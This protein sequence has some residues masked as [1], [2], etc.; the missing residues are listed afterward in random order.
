VAAGQ[1]KRLKSRVPKPFLYLDR[2]RTLLDLCLEAYRKVP[3]LTHVVVVTGKDHFLK[4]GEALKRAGLPGTVTAGGAQRE[5]SVRLGLKVLPPNVKYVLVHDAARPLISPAVIVRVLKET[6]KSGAAIPVVPVKDTLKVV[7]GNRVTKTL[8]R[9]SLR[10]VQTPQGFKAELLIKAF[11]KLGKKASLMTDDAAVV[12]A[13][14]GKV[15]VVD[16]DLLNFK[17]TTPEDLRQAREHLKS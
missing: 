7:S 5:D 4:V 12:E 10:A 16:G 11:K 9:A 1:S 8:E 6:I 17:V 14:G 2:Q 3:G 15:K 13:A